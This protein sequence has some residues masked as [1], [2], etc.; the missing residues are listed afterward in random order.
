MIKSSARL[1]T[2]SLEQRQSALPTV[3]NAGKEIHSPV[4]GVCPSFLFSRFFPLLGRRRIQPNKLIIS[5]PLASDTGNY[6]M[7][8]SGIIIFAVIKAESLFIKILSQVTGLDANV[9]S[10]DC[11][12]Q[13]A[14]EVLDTVGMNVSSNVSFGMVNHFMD[15]FFIQITVRGQGISNKITS[16][17]NELANC[18]RNC[19]SAYIRDNLGLDSASMPFQKPHNGNLA[20]SSSPFDYFIPFGFMHVN[21]F[22]TDKS[23]IRFNRAGEFTTVSTHCQTNSM[24]HKPSCLLSNADTFGYFIRTNPVLVISNHPDS[25]EPFFQTYS[26]ILK[27]S[28][29]FNRELAF[30]VL[31]FTLPYTPSFYIPYVLSSAS[32]TSY[33]V[34]PAQSS[35]I[36]NAYIRIREVIYCFYQCLWLFHC[37]PPNLYTY[38]IAQKFYCVKYISAFSKG[39]NTS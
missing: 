3:Q 29:H 35:D 39:D 11:S 19:F 25:G 4:W 21:R 12:L 26:T 33:S 5:Q 6:I 30:R 9:S 18:V 13:K 32:R 15:I 1:L 23:F 24:H 27:N 2:S 36:L 28:S 16:S 22:T 7:K 20:D 14:P 17:F 31:R 37:Y 34:R 38:M 10:F 8:T